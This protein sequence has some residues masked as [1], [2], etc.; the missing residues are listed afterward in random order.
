MAASLASGA[1][2]ATITE[3]RAPARRAANAT[4]SAAL[5]ALTVQMPPAS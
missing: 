5:P 2:S 4:P 3:Q 1:V